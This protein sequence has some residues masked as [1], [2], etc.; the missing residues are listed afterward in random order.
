MLAVYIAAV[1]I[2]NVLLRL[3]ATTL[4]DRL[5][6]TE[7]S[8]TE[9]ITAI[10]NLCRTWFEAGASLATSPPLQLET[11]PAA[12]KQRLSALYGDIRSEIAE[13]LSEMWHSLGK[14]IETWTSDLLNIDFEINYYCI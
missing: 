14:F 4:R 9:T 12:R 7:E 1:Q 2:T 6:A 8:D 5:H 10:H 11:L 3:L 13:C